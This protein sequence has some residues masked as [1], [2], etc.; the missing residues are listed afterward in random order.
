[1]SNYRIRFWRHRSGLL[2]LAMLAG[3]FAGTS[4]VVADDAENPSSY[5]LG[6][7]IPELASEFTESNLGDGEFDIDLTAFQQPGTRPGTGPR[8]PTRVPSGQNIAPAS[9]EDVGDYLAS[10]PRMFGHAYGSIGQLRATGV[11]LATGKVTN[12]LTDIPMGG[13]AGRLQVGDNN[14]ALAQDRFFFSYNHFAGAIRTNVSGQP[15]NQPIDQYT[16]GLER[17]FMGNISSWQLQLPMTGQF[18]NGGLNSGQ[19]GNL[20]FISKTV[21]WRSDYAS[22]AGGLGLDLPTGS[23]LNGDVGGTRFRL[24]NSSTHLSPFVG[25]LASPTDATF[26]QTFMAVDV[27]ASGNRFLV[28]GLPGTPFQQAG[29]LTT[30]PLIQLDMSGGL[31]FYQNPGG[32]GITGMAFLGEVHYVGALN[33]GDNLIVTGNTAGGAAGFQL[34]NLSNQL[35][36]TNMTAGLHMLW[37]DR[38]QIRIGGAFPL[39]TRPNRSF[40]GEVIAQVNYIP[41]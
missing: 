15:F 34:G 37:N 4:A 27:P 2:L 11:D 29:V 3:T 35:Y 28:S 21:V 32:G 23:S 36:V 39:A 16:M 41:Y 33:R 19:I 5:W 9:A 20:G 18:A 7:E 30:Q 12:I 8:R 22:L 17:A 10:A 1:M 31:W 24:A 26:F 40:D 25:F 14:V 6:E 38:I 13:G